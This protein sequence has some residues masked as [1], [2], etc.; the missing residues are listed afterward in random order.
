MPAFTVETT[1]H[2]PVFR[3]RTFEASSVEHACRLAI[4][5]D[6]RSR[7]QRDYESAGEIYVSGIW[8]GVDAAHYGPA[9]ADPSKSGDGDAQS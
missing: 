5:D 8:P 3:H 4:D 6:D 9:M 7:G 2:L 1:Y